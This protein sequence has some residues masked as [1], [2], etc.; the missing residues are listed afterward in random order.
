MNVNLCWSCRHQFNVA[1]FKL[2]QRLD[3]DPELGACLFHKRGRELDE[4]SADGS[5]QAGF[6]VVGRHV[7][8]LDE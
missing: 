5:D 7:D 4:Y 8:V 3:T 6:G 1:T 2:N